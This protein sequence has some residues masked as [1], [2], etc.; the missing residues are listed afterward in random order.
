MA[1]SS[2]IQDY[3]KAKFRRYPGSNAV[4]HR[5]VR[6]T[7]TELARLGDVRIPED[8]FGGSSR[9]FRCLAWGGLCLAVARPF[10]LRQY[11][12]AGSRK[13]HQRKG[14]SP[15]IH[16]PTEPPQAK[17]RNP[18][19]DHQK[20]LRYSTSRAGQVRFGVNRYEPVANCIRTRIPAESSPSVV[21]K[22]RCVVAIERIRQESTRSGR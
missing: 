2:A 14:R 12:R 13:A 4:R 6:L 15:M 8:L 7:R 19:D 22:S 16:C 17:Q 18:R 5:F 21:L 20:V 9:G 3:L 1:T 10:A 11:D